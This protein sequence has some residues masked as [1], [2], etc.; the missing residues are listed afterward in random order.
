MPT[1]KENIDQYYDIPDGELR[2]HIS[3]T[4]GR[5]PSGQC[6]ASDDIDGFY[7]TYNTTYFLGASSDGVDSPG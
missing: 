7:L 5:T 3:I 2:T 1:K 6:D 4:L